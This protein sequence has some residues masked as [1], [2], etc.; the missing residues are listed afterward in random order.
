MTVRHARFA[1]RALADYHEIIRYTVECFGPI[2]AT[3]Y[4]SLIEQAIK[5]LRADASRVGVIKHDEIQDGLYLY[6]LK[7]SKP[8]SARSVGRIRHPRHLIA[9]RLP[10]G[11]EVHVLRLLHDS[12]DLSSQVYPI[13]YVPM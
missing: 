8:K 13:E 11:M 9:L 1:P 5:D 2:T 4:E 6:H 12:M 7:S 10:S 3:R